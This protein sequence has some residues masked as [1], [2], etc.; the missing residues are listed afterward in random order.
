MKEKRNAKPKKS[1]SSRW[2]ASKHHPTKADLEKNLSIPD[3]TPER[4]AKA[5][6][7]YKLN[8]RG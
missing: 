6:A 8:K 4:L 2:A 1:R 3:T 7:N 5:V